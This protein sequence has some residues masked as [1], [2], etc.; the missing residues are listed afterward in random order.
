MGGGGSERLTVISHHYFPQKRQPQ[1][2]L[3]LRQVKVIFIKNLK[4]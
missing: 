4:D 1:C 3:N 2:T